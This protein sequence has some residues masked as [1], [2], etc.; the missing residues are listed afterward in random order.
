MAGLEEPD[1]VGIHGAPE[2][3][4]EAADDKGKQL[5]AR[6][7]DAHGLGRD[8]ILPDGKRRPPRAGS[9]EVA[10]DDDDDQEKDER[11]DPGGELGDAE[12]SASPLHLGEGEERIGVVQQRL[13]DDGEAQCRDA[14]V[15]APE[16]EHGEAEEEAH[17]R[18]KAAGK[19]DRESEDN[20]HHD[21]RGE[22]SRD[23]RGAEQRRQRRCDGLARNNGNDTRRHDG[24]QV[25][26]ES[27]KNGNAALQAQEPA[28]AK[29]RDRP[30]DDT[31]P[32]HE[33]TGRIA[34]APAPR[35]ISGAVGADS[36]ESPL[37][38]AELPVEPVDEVQ[39]HGHH[40]HGAGLEE[41]ALVKG[42]EDRRIPDFQQER[43]LND[44]E[45]QQDRQR[46]LPERFASQAP[47]QPINPG[48][49]GGHFHDGKEKVCD[50]HFFSSTPSRPTARRICPSV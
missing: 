44:A 31:D 34:V 40:G 12:H 16:G 1:V 23:I 38:E 46:L 30:Q 37:G 2:A 41:Q 43:G 33:K 20:L 5:G 45:G 32:H 18:C 35:D 27:R 4:H 28:H 3:G 7:I 39:P 9:Y 29:E 14:E 8:L 10:D 25:E 26:G 49:Q 47:Q 48:D 11:P 42:G 19:D 15:V 50:F 36:V 21:G 24:D 13:H 17:L 22:G 6:D